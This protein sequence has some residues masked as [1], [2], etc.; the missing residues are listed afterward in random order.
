M[1]SMEKNVVIFRA[2]LS[3]VKERNSFFF[4]SCSQDYSEGVTEKTNL[5]VSIFGFECCH[6]RF[7][8]EKSLVIKNSVHSEYLM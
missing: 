4:F 1:F 8:T 6:F 2:A 3:D 7:N 5:I